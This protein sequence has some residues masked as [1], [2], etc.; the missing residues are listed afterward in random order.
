MADGIEGTWECK[1]GSAVK[2]TITYTDD[3]FFT[4]SFA[5]D[6][7]RQ[8][9]RVK[10]AGQVSGIWSLSQDSLIEHTNHAEL[11]EFKVFGKEKQELDEANAFLDD[12]IG[13][14]N[15]SDVLKLNRRQILLQDARN[16]VHCKR[17]Q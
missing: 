15:V 2:T 8:G 11:T 16:R 9:V 4:S 1:I 7:I 14:T 17:L 3:G 12:L 10:S 5:G 13:Q 6:G